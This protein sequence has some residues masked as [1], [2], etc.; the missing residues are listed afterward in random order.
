M[1]YELHNL[2]KIYGNRTVLD[3]PHLSVE[4]GR[5]VGLL[6]P[7]GAG[8][9]TLLEIFSFLSGPTF[10]EVWFQGKKVDYENNRLRDLR[11][12]VVVVQQHPIM[13]TVPVEK[14]LEFP[15]NIR[16]VPKQRREK[17]IDELLDLVGMREF[18][19]ARAH[20]LSGG[21]TQRIAIARALAC[22]PEV[23]LFDEPTASVD[24]E[25]QIAIE[26]IVQEINQDKNI[27][28]IF[29]THDMN[30]AARL[31][32]EIVFL[33]EGRLAKSTYENIFSGQILPGE[34][35]DPYC[36]VQNKLKLGI[37]SGKTGP[38]RI[39]IDPS[40]IKVSQAAH[41]PPPANCFKGRL[42]QLTDEK[43]KVRALV[44]VGLPLCVLISKEDLTA[45]SL[46]VGSSIWLTCPPDSI[47][48]I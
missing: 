2:K 7:N 33:F 1:L 32:D 46:G 43:K 25:N 20:N 17:V 12:R 8:K 37:T 27:S 36:L 19:H 5:I 47:E 42:V 18:K 13:F 38:V 44:D 23:I 30:Q 22:S 26:R 10:G 21:E 48:I 41:Y 11:R 15:L 45:M 34:N 14:N 6:G 4:A 40:A 28:V 29:T 16:K 24:V 3:L 31:A 39:A 9:T 35:G